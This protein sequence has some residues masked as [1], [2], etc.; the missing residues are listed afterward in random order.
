M[1]TFRLTNID[2]HYSIFTVTLL[3][4]KIGSKGITA[5]KECYF[6]TEFFAECDV[7]LATLPDNFWAGNIDEDYQ[8]NALLYQNVKTYAIGHGCAATWDE[9]GVPTKIMASVCPSMR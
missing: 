8:L 2:E 7:P 3:N 5:V 6:Q 1:I 4:T 9:N